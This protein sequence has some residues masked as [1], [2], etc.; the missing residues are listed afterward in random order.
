MITFPRQILVSPANQTVK[1][2]RDL[3]KE[4]VGFEINRDKVSTDVLRYTP[5]WSAYWTTQYANRDVESKKYRARDHLRSLSTCIEKQNDPSSRE[6]L[7]KF[8]MIVSEAGSDIADKNY[9]IDEER[10]KLLEGRGGGK[11]LF[12]DVLKLGA[13]VGAGE[14]IYINLD[15]IPIINN[16]PLITDLRPV[17]ALSAVGLSIHALNYLHNKWDER[18]LNKIEEKKEKFA[19]NRV[20][21]ATIDN[22]EIFKECF[23]YAVKGLEE[24]LKFIV[25]IEETP[26]VIRHF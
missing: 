1:Y 19:E 6:Y 15:K 2:W 10:K 13:A 26:I 4:E 8:N 23:P 25:D 21:E 16:L 5:E 7:E 24:D 9:K 11:E 20:K 17:P 14:M 3:L 22:A 12:L 18:K